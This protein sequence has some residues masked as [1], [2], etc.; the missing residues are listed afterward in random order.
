MVCRHLSLKRPQMNMR[1]TLC[2]GLLCLTPHLSAQPTGQ[3]YRNT[4]YGFQFSV[5]A[6][7]TVRETGFYIAHYSSVFLTVNNQRPGLEIR[8]WPTGKNSW[9]FGAET[10][11]QQMQPGEVYVSFGYSDG[12]GPDGMQPDT[13]ATDLRSLLAGKAIT[14]SSQPGLSPLN[15]GFFKR[16]HRWAISACL[17]EP[18]TEENRAKV[19]SMLQSFEFLDAPVG[20][21]GWAE[22]LA[23]AELPENI[24]APV[25]WRDWPVANSVQEDSA[26]SQ[27]GRLTVVVRKTG[28]GYSV[29]FIWQAVGAWEYLV[30]A[31]GKVTQPEPAVLYPLSLPRAELPFDLPGASPGRVNAYWLAPRVQASTAFG[32]TTVTWFAEDG[33]VRRQALD[34][35]GARSGHGFVSV[36]G[37]PHT[38]E[39]VNEDWRI[40]PHPPGSGPLDGHIA[41]TPDSRVV[42]DQFSSKAGWA[43]LGI[44]VHGQRVN[45]LGPFMP[46]YP[47]AD[48]VLNDDGS[49]A[50]LVWQ[51]EAKTNAQVVVLNTNGVV[52]FRADCGHPVWSPIVA[53]NG[54]GVLLRPN[55]GAAADRNTFMWFTARGKEQAL[56]ISPNPE[57][58]G[59]IPESRKALFCTSLGS[60]PRRWQLI[61]WDTGKR[62]WDIASPGAGQFLA[63][64]LTPTLVIFAMAEPYGPS[65]S[66]SGKVQIRTFFAVKVQDGSLAARWQGPLAHRVLDAGTEGFLR[67]GSRVF[68]ITDEGVQRTQSGRHCLEK[69]WLGMKYEVPA[70]HKWVNEDAMFSTELWPPGRRG[71]GAVACMIFSATDFFREPLV[72][73][74]LF[75]WLVAPGVEAVDETGPPSSASLRAGSTPPGTQEVTKVTPESFEPI[76]RQGFGDLEKKAAA[77]DAIARS[78]VGARYA[79]GL[80]V[81]EDT[82]KGYEWLKKAAKSGEIRAQRRVGDMLVAGRG[83]SPDVKQGMEW[84]TKA[85]E[86]GDAQAQFDLALAYHEGTGVARDYGKAFDWSLKVAQ[87]GDAISQRRVGGMSAEGEGVG[88]DLRAAREWW[89]KAAGQNEPQALFN[90]GMMY[91]SGKGVEANRK[92]A[93]SLWLR[94]SLYGNPDAQV[95]LAKAYVSGGGVPKDMKR[96]MDLFEAGARAGNAEA[97]VLFRTPAGGGEDGAARLPTGVAVARQSRRPRLSRR[98]VPVGHFLSARGGGG[99]GCRRSAQVVSLGCRPRAARGDCAAEGNH[100]IHGAGTSTGSPAP[101][102]QSL[103]PNRA[104]WYLI[105]APRQSVRFVAGFA[106]R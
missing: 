54:A 14:P 64:G 26:S 65:Q 79:E 90:L 52:Q 77:G 30:S 101:G 39:G 69:T 53:P 61:D 2:F 29:K 106:F 35:H 18:V 97:Q 43:S 73:C 84:L 92:A 7:W 100:A 33:S 96:A 45:S 36:G 103:S 60:E 57:C 41:A 80:G 49:A 93:L 25:K 28:S 82:A 91:F 12:P 85:A 38:M 48:A 104:I 63:L 23:W 66:D 1:R 105:T 5:P 68:Y 51:D 78:E 55:T 46:C 44:Y 13:V 47:S 75:F 102:G 58:A 40:V 99:Q 74:L 83:T 22:S 70:A 98:P 4:N 37:P 11:F 27:M 59:W 21:P 71:W 20:N 86:A 67:L 32:K 94:A 24:R 88:K 34:V 19:L 50:W 95:V 9:G 15:V 72:Q 89:E 31:D 56:D 16:G 3:T 17:K 6:G 76:S 62:L 8:D 42:L 81:K 10:T 87:R